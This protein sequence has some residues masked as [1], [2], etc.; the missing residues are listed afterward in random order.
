MGFSRLL[1]FDSVNDEV[2]RPWKKQQM[3]KRVRD[4]R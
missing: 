4:E 3:A 1:F 2:K